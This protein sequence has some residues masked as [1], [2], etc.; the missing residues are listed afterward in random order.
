VHRVAKFSAEPP[1]FLSKVQILCAGQRQQ[2]DYTLA[3]ALH[4]LSLHVFKGKVVSPPRHAEDEMQALGGDSRA[5]LHGGCPCKLLETPFHQ[6]INAP[7][8]TSQAVI[9][10]PALTHCQAQ[11]EREQE[12]GGQGRKKKKRKSE[13]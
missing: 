6:S 1:A 7:K 13:E 3:F 4:L 11:A 9:P 2:G 5:P 10:V 12:G 8:L